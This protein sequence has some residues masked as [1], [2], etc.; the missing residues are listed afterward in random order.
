MPERRNLARRETSDDPRAALRVWRSDRAGSWAVTRFSDLPLR[1]QQFDGLTRS[2]REVF[3]HSLE[4]DFCESRVREALAEDRAAVARFQ[5][6]DPRG[7]QAVAGY[8]DL[9][10]HCLARWDSLAAS[11]ARERVG[12]VLSS[13]RYYRQIAAGSQFT[14]GAIVRQ[15][16][17]LSFVTDEGESQR[18]TTSL[19]EEDE[20]YE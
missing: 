3:W 11:R 16:L 15:S 12:D 18:D 6:T 20:G 9:W 17:D 13:R 4:H 8:F 2:G 7:S 14:Y 5:R 1:S 10:L 19:L